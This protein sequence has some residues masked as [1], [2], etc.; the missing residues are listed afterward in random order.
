MNE[1]KSTE[2]GSGTA[3]G[4]SKGIDVAWLL[5]STPAALLLASFI[6]FAVQNAERVDIEFL[7]WTFATRRIVVLVAAAI[8]GAVIWE[9]GKAI[10][11]RK[12]NST[13]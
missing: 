11:R 9:L 8:V 12:R 10:V 7:G 2:P 1:P 4:Q 5:R 13:E 3:D 6:V